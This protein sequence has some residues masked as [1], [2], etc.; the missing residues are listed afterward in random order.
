MMSHT[1]HTF[2][3]STLAAALLAAYGPAMAA[4]DTAAKELTT[5]ESWVSIGAGV[6]TGDDR[7]QLGIVGGLR[8]EGGYLLLDADINHRDDATGTWQTLQVSNMGM[9]SREIRAEYQQQGN[10]G[11]AVEYRQSKREVPYMVNTGVTGLGTAE[12]YV[13]PT[14]TMT[15]QTVYVPGTGTN[16]QLGTERTKY[17][18]DFFK[19]L[20][21][22]LK[23]KLSASNE[24]KE[25]DR[26]A[27]VGG[28]PE[29]AAQPIDWNVRKIDATFD[30]V[31]DK[32][33]LSGGYS[34][35]WFQNDN[36]L[37]TAWRRGGGTSSSGTNINLFY[38]YY[39]SQPLDSEAHQIFLDGGYSFTPTTRGTF[40]LSYTHATQDEHIPT[41][42]IAAITGMS[43]F[44]AAATA[45]SNLDGEVNTTLVQL[46]LTSRPIPKLNLVASLR[47]HKV[48]EQTPE[49]FVV[50]TTTD[51]HSTPL[52]YK[53]LSGKLEGTY[54][55]PQGFNLT[56][57]I[58]YSNQDRTVPFGYYVDADPDPAVV[59]LVDNERYVPWRSELEEIT[60][61]LQL[62]RSMS[63]TVNGAVAFLHSK[64]DGSAYA[65][66]YHSDPGEGIH[67]ESIDPI[68]ITDRERNK[69]RL[70]VD[71]MPS[72]ALN[73]Q[74]NYE[75]AK[76]D[77][78]GHTY[79]LRDGKAWLFSADAS[80]SINKDWQVTGWYSH[81]KTEAYQRGWRQ[82]S[83]CW[84]NPPT[85]TIPCADQSTTAAELDKKDYFDDTGD[86][87]GL[88]VKGLINPKLKIGAD[89]QWTRTKSEIYQDLTVVT[90]TTLGTDVYVTGTAE[91]QLPDITSTMTRI[92]L[93][94][95]YALKKNADLRFDVIHERWKSDDWS[96]QFADGTPFVFGAATGTSRS[97]GTMIITYPKQN[98]TFIGARYKYKF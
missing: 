93:F 53:T 96:W 38:P 65:E 78:S 56:A 67:P 33:Q 74:F 51:A 8:D 22:N 24:D 32:L 49:W 89:L 64:R 13:P 48:D 87:V 69:L 54:N 77:Y 83:T 70:T 50:D 84:S 82:G 43:G 16:F 5:P 68:N 81:D 7:R 75:N 55:L 88:G 44:P 57:G 52:D 1:K 2:A 6:L 12:Q 97:D 80:Y 4:E 58:D 98:S 85:N 11:V 31:Q 10:Q 63:E 72:D 41:D 95:E 20:T 36:D 47:Y 60:Y 30:Y 73:L 15:G 42:D 45:P 26:H 3:L 91:A 66:A 62:R 35:S 34:G 59:E 90:T 19:Y 71:W 79:G 23:L 46:G 25:G 27:R 92:A 28:Q 9:T 86:S 17:G 18:L 21:P 40:K 37:L 76:D 39:I 29:F 14:T 61:R 94:A